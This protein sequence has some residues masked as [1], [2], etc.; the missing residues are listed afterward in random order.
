MSGCPE[1][2]LRLGGKALGVC[3]RASW[4]W[5]P[6]GFS[7]GLTCTAKGSSE[8]SKNFIFV[9]MR[10][11]IRKRIRFEGETLSSVLDKSQSG[12]CRMCPGR[13]NRA[14]S[15]AF[16]EPSRTGLLCSRQDWNV[17]PW[18]HTSCQAGLVARLCTPRGAERSLAHS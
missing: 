1:T 13:W 3:S 11:E 12:G 8:V 5:A 9:G 15:H 6:G 18:G 4:P 2:Q 14:G 16:P 7:Q 10:K 17:P